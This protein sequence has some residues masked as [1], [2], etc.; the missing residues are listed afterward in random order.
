MKLV[1]AIIKPFTLDE[2]FRKPKEVRLVITMATGN[3]RQ[4]DL[5]RTKRTNTIVIRRCPSMR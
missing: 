2:D 4:K 5:D 3:M 1:L